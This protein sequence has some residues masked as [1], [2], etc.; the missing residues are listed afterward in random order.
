MPCHNE[1]VLI[2]LLKGTNYKR[3]EPASGAI[4][5]ANGIFLIGTV[6]AFPLLDVQLG[7]FFAFMLLIVWIII[8][9]LLIIQF[10]HRDF[11]LPFIQHPVQSF[12]IGTWI[13]GVSVLCNVFLKYFPTLLPLTQAMAILNT[14]LWLFF[15][16]NCFYNFKQL[17]FDQKKYPVQG[18]I[19]LSTVGTQSIMVLLNNVFFQLPKALSSAVI[20]LG[21]IFYA[22]GIFLIGDRYL[23]H[24]EWNLID[25]W[26]N[27]NCII[28][29]ALSITGL[30][31]ATTSTFTS[32][33]INVLWII[34]FVLLVIIEIIEIIRAVFRVKTYGWNEGIFRYHITQWSRNFTFGM[35]YTFS[36]IMQQNPYYTIPD[37]LYTFQTKFMM[38]WAWIVLFALLGQI[39][40]YVKSQLEAKQ[41]ARN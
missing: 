40:I 41:V 25:D 37:P 14:F 2:L 8:Y 23:K 38:F 1:D 33:F 24:K 26:A 15:L 32:T 17:L 3:I 12:A 30:A 5:M 28:H 18:V 6:E 20:I 22:A 29:G 21:L 7:K 39:A 31:I 34:V 35:F 11:L 4:V 13:A 16:A 9:S 36:L 19:L 10:F 27:T